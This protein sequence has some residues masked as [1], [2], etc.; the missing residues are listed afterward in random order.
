M[1]DG[2]LF[3]FWTT[4]VMTHYSVVKET[5]CLHV[6]EMQFGNLPTV[7]ENAVLSS[8][9]LS[10][11][12]LL[13]YWT[14]DRL[15]CWVVQVGWKINESS[16]S[17]VKL[18]LEESLKWSWKEWTICEL[19]AAELRHLVQLWISSATCCAVFRKRRMNH[20]SLELLS[21]FSC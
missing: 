6:Q 21:A 10:H 1:P 2:I 15:N 8:S 3:N 5:D 4:E 14:M 7:M 20:F 18:L 9:S 13:L 12:G 11:P 17:Y 16:F 19:C